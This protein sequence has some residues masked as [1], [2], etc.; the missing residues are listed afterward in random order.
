MHGHD[1]VA[2][3]TEG[4]PTKGNERFTVIHE[5]ATYRFANKENRDAF[6]ANPAKYK[7]A[8]GGYCAYGVSLGA[9]FDGKPEY[10]KIVDG[11]LYLN[12]SRDA[13]NAWNKNIPGHIVKA[14]KNWPKIIDK[15][16]SELQ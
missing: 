6:V 4:K 3:F 7:P 15:T 9:K 13:Q 16:P 11:K 1:V 10:W 12:L 8:Y 2:Y 14:D 5:E